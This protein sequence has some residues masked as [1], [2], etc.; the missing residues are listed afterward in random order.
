MTVW[1]AI[2]GLDRIHP[3]DYSDGTKLRWLSDFDGQVFRDLFQ[4]HEDPPVAEFFGY[5]ENTDAE[6]AELLIEPPWTQVYILYL[7]M[8]TE[9]H[10]GDAVRCNNAAGAFYAAWRSYT[11]WYNRTH[12]PKGPAAL[13]FL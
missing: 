9:L 6:T 5:D 3:N 12:P 8:K 11:D 13:R 4:T 2:R 10:N 1:E 7:M